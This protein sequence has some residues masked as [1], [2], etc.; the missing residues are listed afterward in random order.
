MAT[1]PRPSMGVVDR[2]G[3]GARKALTQAEDAAQTRVVVDRWIRPR[4]KDAVS[5]YLAILAPY[6]A[7][8]GKG[9]GTGTR[10]PARQL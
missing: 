3:G 5:K 7:Q 10:P 8:G 2:A 1:G 6:V 4:L 9:H